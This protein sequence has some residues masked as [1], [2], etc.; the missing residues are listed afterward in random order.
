MSRNKPADPNFEQRVRTSFE[1]QNAMYEIGARIMMIEP[2]HVQLR[3]EHRTQFTQ[4]HGFLHAGI[5]A[6]AMDSACGYAAFSL[7]DPDAAV[8]TT[9]YKINLLRPAAASSYGIDGTVV[10]AGRTITVAQAV[11]RPAD[12]DE[13]MAIMI[14][15][16]IALIG[17]SIQH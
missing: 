11:A 7:M 16:L 1:A 8:L 10:R 3:L 15:T 4:Q 14:A 9:E 17:T 2:G 12:D 5:L 13:P 6:A